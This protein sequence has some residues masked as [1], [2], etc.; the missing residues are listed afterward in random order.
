M[1]SLIDE[2]ITDRRDLEGIET[3]ERTGYPC[4]TTHVAPLLVSVDGSRASGAALRVASEL[5]RHHGTAIEALLVEPPFPA[6]V[7]GVR[8]DPLSLREIEIPRSTRFARVQRQLCASLHDVPWSLRVEFGRV[9]PTIAEAARACDARLIVMGLS[10]RQTPLRLASRATSI[11]VLRRANIPVFAVPETAHDLPCTAVV[12]VD[13]SPASLHAARETC[14][15]LGRPATVHLVHV[16]ADID[17]PIA[18]VGGWSEIYQTGLSAV[19]EKLA[20]KLSGDGLSVQSRMTSGNVAEALL[21]V[22][23][24]ERADLVACGSHGCGPVEHFLVGSVPTTLVRDAHCSVL[25]APSRE[26]PET[27]EVTR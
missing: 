4:G 11:R 27:Q 20:A 23:E 26:H 18:D 2:P 22:V 5:A 17:W 10:A 6:A 24:R 9:A 25:V 3:F 8:I 15:L 21:R 7:R 16:R 19:L 14:N 13:F 12:G 1:P